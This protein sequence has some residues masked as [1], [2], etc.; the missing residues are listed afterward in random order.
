MYFFILVLWIERMRS[1]GLSEIL[2][3]KGAERE[4]NFPTGQKLSGSADQSC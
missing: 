4:A 3:R 2:Y 1:A